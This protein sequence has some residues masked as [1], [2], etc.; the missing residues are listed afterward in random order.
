MTYDDY[1]NSLNKNSRRRFCETNRGQKPTDSKYV[2]AKITDDIDIEVGKEYVA[3]LLPQASKDNSH[4]EYAIT[5]YQFGLREIRGTGSDS[6]I[7][8]NETH[9]WE[10]LSTMVEVPS[11]R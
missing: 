8:N 10:G 5:G 3:L 2:Q 9:A 7:L 1:W 11:Q 4:S 6:T